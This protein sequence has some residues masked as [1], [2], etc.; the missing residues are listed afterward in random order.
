VKR[1]LLTLL[2]AG[3]LSAGTLGAVDYGEFASDDHKPVIWSLYSCL[4]SRDFGTDRFSLT[5]N[6]GFGFALYFLINPETE[7]TPH[8][9]L[10]FT[11]D[12]NLSEMFRKQLVYT[13]APGFLVRTYIPFLKL[14]YGAGAHVKVGHTR[15]PAWG[16]YGQ[17]MVD[18]HRFFLGSRIVFH[19]GS[20]RIENEILFGYLF[21]G[22]YK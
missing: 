12:N 18:F 15:Y 16:V 5:G 4:N 1:A 11:V 2:L 21:S 20:D 14:S 6:L 13:L 10:Y 3:L 9:L 8:K 22:R 19:P 17:A 7:Y